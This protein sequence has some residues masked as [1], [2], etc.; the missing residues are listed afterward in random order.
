MLFASFW[1][2]SRGILSLIEV[3]R[4]RIGHSLPIVFALNPI[5]KLASDGINALVNACARS[6]IDEHTRQ[7]ANQL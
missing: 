1:R 6:H 7:R 3:E 2:S 4:H 5:I